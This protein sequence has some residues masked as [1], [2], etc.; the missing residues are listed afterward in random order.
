MSAELVT[1]VT[2]VDVLRYGFGNTWKNASW[3]SLR[4]E[5]GTGRVLET[6][7]DRE[8][9]A[10]ADEV[11]SY[12]YDDAGNPT[13]ISSNAPGT[14]ADQT[15]CY[16]YD[17]LRQ[18]NAAWTQAGAGA[19]CAGSADAAT[20]GGPN[21]FALTWTFDGAGNR[22]V[23][24][25]RTANGSA[26]ATG[27]PVT[28]STSAYLNSATNSAVVGHRLKD[29]THTLGATTLGVDR[30][31][32]DSA[33]NT[34]DRD[35]TAGSPAAQAG[36]AADQWLSWD[37]EGELAQIRA[38]S[39]TGAVIEDNAYDSDGSRLVR[40]TATTTTVFLGDLEVTLDRTKASSD[41]ARFAWKRHYT[42]DGKT[43]AV[44][45]G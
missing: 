20:I 44:R 3:Q 11:L 5:E 35:I 34:S 37:A 25:S 12:S 27:A 14:T 4:F 16:R 42:F 40:R 28:T 43:I 13:K 22:T 33:G 19:T 23:Q 18:L 29:V 39:A 15:R 38:G 30:F 31:A 9:Q 24:T 26:G 8:D 2:A 10:S 6:R 21:P 32:Y 36:T 1:K 7:L 41:P 45:D 17:A